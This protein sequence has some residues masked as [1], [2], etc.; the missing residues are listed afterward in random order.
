MKNLNPVIKN[1][2]KEAFEIL[3]NQGIFEDVDG[4]PRLTEAGFQKIYQ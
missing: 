1:N 2:L 4:N 3:F